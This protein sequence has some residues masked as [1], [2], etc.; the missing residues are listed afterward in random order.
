MLYKQN[1]I[2]DFSLGEWLRYTVEAGNKFQEEKFKLILS[3]CYRMNAEMRSGD[4]SYPVN[5]DV[6]FLREEHEMRVLDRKGLSEEEKR[7]NYILE[8]YLDLK[9]R[10]FKGF[11]SSSEVSRFI[12]GES[13]SLIGEDSEREEVF[14][15]FEIEY[16]ELMATK[17]PISRSFSDALVS[18]YNEAE[19][20]G[21]RRNVASQNEL[22]IVVGANR[23]WGPV[24]PG[25]LLRV[26][27]SHHD[28]YTLH[29]YAY[30][31]GWT[32]VGGAEALNRDYS[33][34]E[35]EEFNFSSQVNHNLLFVPLS[36]FLKFCKLKNLQFDLERYSN[37]FRPYR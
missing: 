18:Y 1:V 12:K 34:V 22:V 30:G 17:F 23:S 2:Y 26:E 4:A 10:D 19:G 32:V 31:R 20:L 24:R 8:L 3:N 15:Q 29:S 14:R 27:I 6:E 9:N 28:Q 33:D 35:T 11:R 36:D 16:R 5:F 21:L 25:D 7:E 37:K 13:P